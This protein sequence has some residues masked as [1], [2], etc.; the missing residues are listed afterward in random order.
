[1]VKPIDA[2]T[3]LPRSAD[4][5]RL[6][7]TAAR[8]AD[9]RSHLQSV[10]FSHEVSEKARSVSQSDKAEKA[11]IGPGSGEGGASYGGGM[12]RKR[13]R[14]KGGDGSLKQSPHPSKGQIVDI[15]GA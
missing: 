7:D 9:I 13:K 15:H 5:A 2:I 11:K 8:Q 4:V 10:S 12:S 14:R 1:L 6:A 3:S